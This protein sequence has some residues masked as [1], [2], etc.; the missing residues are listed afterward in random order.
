LSKAIKGS[1]IKIEAL[2]GDDK[3]IEF[4]LTMNISNE[5]VSYF[6]NYEPIY[7]E[8][9]SISFMYFKCKMTDS[10]DGL[11]AYINPT[12]IDL[13]NVDFVQL[14]SFYARSQTIPF[15]EFVITIKCF[16]FYDTAF[17]GRC[18]IGM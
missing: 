13:D 1:I 16:N 14:F 6:K 18:T 9:G 5:A 10:N 17:Y 15:Y 3:L 8:G 7:V 4:P 11:I 2:D 12:G